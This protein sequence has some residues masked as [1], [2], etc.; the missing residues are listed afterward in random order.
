MEHFN[1]TVVDYDYDNANRLTGLANLTA[2]GGGAIA[3]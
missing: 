1:G 2:Q 3:T